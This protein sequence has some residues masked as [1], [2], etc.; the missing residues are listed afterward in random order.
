MAQFFKQT[1]GEGFN[2]FYCGGT[3][4]RA[5]I[6]VVKKDNCLTLWD[7]RSVPCLLITVA[8][9]TGCG[10]SAIAKQTDALLGL[11]RELIMNYS[12][13]KHDEKTSYN[14]K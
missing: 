6:D 7:S 1:K 12:Y 8:L 5:I 2:L 14:S 11:L 10:I 4:I 13:S 9:Q 3:Y